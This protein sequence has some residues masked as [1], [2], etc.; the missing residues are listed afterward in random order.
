MSRE[1][2][3]LIKF[4]GLYFFTSSIAG[5][6]LQIYL[7]K[8]GGFKAVA[9]YGLVSLIFLFIFYIAS[10]YFLKKIS[11]VMMIRIGLLFNAILYFLIFFL[12]DNSLS[13]LFPLGILS[14]IGGGF[15]WSGFNLSQYIATHEESRNEYFGKQNFFLNLANAS[16]PL[17][18]GLIIFV[19][20]YFGNV[21][22]GYSLTFLLV[23]LL[24]FS[25]FVLIKD[26]TKHTGA[27]FTINDIIKHKRSLKWKIVLGQQFLY[28]LFDV[29]FSAFSAVLIY[30]IVK[31][32]VYVGALNTIST[33]IFAVASLVAIGILKKYKHAYFL[34]AL[35]NS[36]G[37]LIFALEQNIFG[38]LILVL[39]NF[40]GPVMNIPA[41]KIIYDVIDD[42]KQDWTRK[43][44]FLV[45]RDS[46]LGIARILTYSVLFFLLNSNNN[47]HVAK[48]W[49]FIIPVFP[50]LIGLLQYYYTILLQKKVQT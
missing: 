8:L 43:Y 46:I 10:G 26:T 38:V 21:T 16:G 35:L 14:G 5:I 24:L 42:E 40:S 29:A 4:I 50:L 33:I 44:H 12:K 9:Q 20:V 23:A 32:E 3:L 1:E 25:L 45:E 22:L 19:F 28:G 36:T 15:F 34:G 39:F 7:F 11:Q 6:F 47:P 30:L 41:S 48:V 13:Y 18:G 49:I 2:K 27:S 17:L 31:Q 37:L